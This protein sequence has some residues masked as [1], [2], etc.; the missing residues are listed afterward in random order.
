VAQA[1]AVLRDRNTIE[2]VLEFLPNVSTL[3][4]GDGVQE[5]I[6]R[7]SVAPLGPR[8]DGSPAV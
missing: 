8:R 5:G 6:S 2:D 3:S 4:H 7:D 1:I